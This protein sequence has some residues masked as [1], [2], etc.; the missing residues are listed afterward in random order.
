MN[1]I[2][3]KYIVIYFITIKYIFPGGSDGK[4]SAMWE[5]WV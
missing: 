1:Y 3:I 5:T 2:Y 4:E